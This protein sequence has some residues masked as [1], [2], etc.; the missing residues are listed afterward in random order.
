MASL[1]RTNGRKGLLKVS[2]SPCG[3]GLEEMFLL[4]KDGR[5]PLGGTLMIQMTRLFYWWEYTS[6]FQNWKKRDHSNNCSTILVQND[7][8]KYVHGSK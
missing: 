5:P 7:L 8:D 1:S 4:G 6:L 3:L 2:V